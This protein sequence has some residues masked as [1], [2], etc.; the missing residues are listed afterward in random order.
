MVAAQ[1]CDSGWRQMVIWECA[2][3]GVDAPAR[4][5]IADR[6]SRW[7]SSTRKTGEIKGLECH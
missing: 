4:E 5:A 7:L 6:A 1:L 2:L 3:R